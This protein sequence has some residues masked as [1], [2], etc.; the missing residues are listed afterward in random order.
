MRDLSD[1]TAAA[2]A[3][4]FLALGCIG[5]IAAANPALAQDAGSAAGEA[6]TAPRVL[7]AVTV[8]DSAI[9]EGSYKT[10][11]AASPKYTAPL[12][13]TPRT[14]TVIP[15]QVLQDNATA[16]LTDALRF[17]PGITLGAGEGG[18]PQGDRPF[19]RGADAQNS[20]FLDGVRDIGAQSRDVF[21]IDQIEVVKGS[22]STMNGRGSVGGAIN[23][24]SKQP[25]D[26]RIV[27]A[28][29][30]TGTAEY[31]RVTADVNQPIGDFAAVRVAAMVH[32]QSVAGRDAIWQSRWGVAP[33]VKFG[34]TGP[35]SLTLDYYHLE[36]DELP[37]SGI[38]YLYTQNNAPLGYSETTVAKTPRTAFYGLADRDFRRNVVN[39]GTA[40]IEHKFGNGLTLRNTTRYGVTSQSYV[41]TQPDDSQGNVVRGLVWRRANSRYSRTEG[42]INQTDF[43]G[44][45]DVGGI[46]NTFAITGEISRELADVGNYVS[47]AATGA[48][49]STGTTLADRCSPANIARYN[50]TT[51]ANPNPYDPWV[52]YAGDT[53]TTPAAIQRS[54][55]QTWTRSRANTQAISAFDTIA[56]SEAVLLNLGLRYDHYVTRVSPG[57]AA[58][59]PNEDGR[60]WFSRTDNI[61]TWQAGLTYKPAPN[62]SIYASASTAATPPGSYL[63]NGSESNALNTTSQALTDALKVE[64]TRSYEVGTKW[65]LFGE[66]LALTLAA[67]QTETKNA[68]ATDANN[69]VSF[70]GEKRVRGIEVTA[71][72]NVT[73]RWNVF[74]GY[75]YMDS[76]IVNGGNSAVTLAGKTY[77]IPAPS[78]GR[79]FPNTPEHSFTATT[80]YKVT[81]KVTL[82]ANGLY[83]SKVYGGY[84]AGIDAGGNV[85]RTLARYV[86]GYW[87]FDANASVQITPRFG[88]QVNVNNLFDKRYY[89]KAFASHFAS[90]AAGRT[91]ILTANVKL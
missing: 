3:P 15:K 40:R 55:P 4:R 71:S 90:Q 5:L 11:R 19:I 34:L 64:R 72:G 8:T 27:Q 75:T 58:T 57:L 48:A 73:D 49:I 20:L 76:E 25:T 51:L 63:G 87:R 50:C 53:S 67:F 22:D 37:D 54:A 30:A 83:M 43:F 24:V 16:S 41:L 23:L 85:V 52:S 6:G 60:Q 79:Q 28:A 29:L 45:F 46:K 86:P 39:I 77:I 9:T 74:A 89:D 21:A 1:R 7:G 78:T 56:F 17:V 66:G 81:D 61:W 12:L 38:P 84:A 32:D 80:T 91:A 62:G 13:D 33:S 65:N 82:G 47:N 36:S 44:S 88:L 31:K 59:A 42:F 2:G 10:E 70:I 35:T 14:V 68:R 26:E 69:T 18:N